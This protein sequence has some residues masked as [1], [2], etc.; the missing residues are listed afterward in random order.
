[1]LD[2]CVNHLLD[3]AFNQGIWYA[4]L[5][6]FFFDS[7]H[8]ISFLISAMPIRPSFLSFADSDFQSV[9]QLAEP[10]A[11]DSFD[12]ESGDD[13]DRYHC[14]DDNIDNLQCRHIQALLSSLSSL[15]SVLD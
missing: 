7:L 14:H 15:P 12:D 13:S 8:D 11:L 5:V 6:A 9:I 4:K 2:D 3:E 1:M 10:F